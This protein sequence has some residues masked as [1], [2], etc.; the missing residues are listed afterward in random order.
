MP[1]FHLTCGLP[2]AGKTTLARQLE[3]KHGALRLTTDEWLLRLFGDDITAAE[4]EQFRARLEGLL[5]DLAVQALQRG[6]DVVLDFGVWSRSEREEF[7]ARAAA[8]GA[9]TE[10]HFLD[11]P[12][13]ELL[14]RLQVRNRTQSAGTFRI[15]E[16][17]LRLWA[18]W[19]ER[20]DA[21]ELPPREPAD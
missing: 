8:V 6:V 11:V 3:R 1:T 7:R 16:A 5:L 4:N 18:T 12:L 17:Q 10:L 2:G 21:D 9:R 15:S 14:A 19:F 20:P 13:D